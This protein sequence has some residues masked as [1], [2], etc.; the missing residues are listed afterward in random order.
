VTVESRRITF[1]WGSGSPAD[2]LRVLFEESFRLQ[3][4]LGVLDLPGVV[5]QG[6]KLPLSVAVALQSGMRRTFLQHGSSAKKSG[7]PTQHTE[8]IDEQEIRVQ[9]QGYSSYV[10]QSVGCDAV[11]SALKKGRVRLVGWAYPGAAERHVGFPDVTKCAYSP[12]EALAACFA[13]VGC[14]SFEVPRSGGAGVLAIVEPSDLVAFARTRPF[15]TPAA[16][17]NAYVTGPGDAV[18]AVNLALRLHKLQ[19]PGVAACHGVLL[20]VLP[21]ASQQK[22]RARTVTLEAIQEKDLDLYEEIEATLPTRIR[23]TQAKEDDEDGAEDPGQGFFAATSALRAFATEN[24]AAGRPWHF[25]FT[26]AT[27]G[28]KKPRFIHYYKERDSKN[29]GALYL[30]EKKG[31]VAMTQHLEATQKSFVRSVQTAFRQ[32]LGAISEETAELAQQT[33]EKRW[34][35]ERD[36]WRLAFAGAKTADQIR[37]ALADLWSRGGSNRELRENWEAILPLLQPDQW[38][39]ARDLALVALASYAGSGKKEANQS[40]AGAQ[41]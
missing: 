38:E 11:L 20:K 33:R 17:S 9:V 4:K 24:L 19:R 7:K 34:D 1:D 2:V 16:L 27:D 25:N 31:L 41:S 8:Q 18:L 10:H 36:R 14:L 13:L 30:D 29:L 35:N 37:K 15:L 12:S 5:R 6:H 28:G 39:T 40:P 3:P 21:W 32:R 23:E 22:S 26:T